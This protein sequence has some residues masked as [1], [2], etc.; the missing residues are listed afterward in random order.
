MADQS[1]TV[2]EPKRSVVVS[3]PP[4]FVA[5]SDDGTIV[6]TIHKGETHLVGEGG[7]IILVPTPSRDPADPLNW[8]SLRKWIIVVLLV[9]WCGSGLSVQQFITNILPSIEIAFPTATP[10]QINLLVSVVTPLIAPGE[11]LLVPVAIT[12]GRRPAILISIV[13][14][15]AST[16]LAAC[17]TSY[18]Q[19]LG[20]RIL[21]GFACGPTD[22]I[23]FTIVQDLSFQHQRGV[24][25]G[26][27]MNG[28]SAM[29]YLFAIITPYMV[30][31]KWPFV[32][33]SA[34][35]GVS[36]VA[37]FFMMPETSYDRTVSDTLPEV[38]VQ[39][40]KALRASVA[41]STE[42][43]PFDYKRQIQLF[44]KKAAGPDGD[45]FNI[46]RRMGLL[47]LNPVVWWNALLNSIVTGYGPYYSWSGACQLTE[48]QGYDR[49]FNVFCVFAGCAALELAI[50]QCRLNQYCRYFC[51]YQ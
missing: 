8:S 43:P 7:S 21:Q 34:L 23:I 26:L 1:A 42:Y 29:T 45:F 10:A 15:L 37:I 19:L 4:Q 17:A 2:N 41:E 48:M 3:S 49:V 24:M 30:N 14:L 44:H 36:L 32:M 11:L 51:H 27:A 6:K 40:H 22:A 25:L 39:D 38:T 12:Y 9:I 16:I 47:M 50:A 13:V 35:F 31:F 28:N 5:E 46:F 33:F 18:E 20:A